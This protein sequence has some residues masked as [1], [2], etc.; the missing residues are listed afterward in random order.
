MAGRDDI[1]QARARGWSAET[2]AERYTLDLERVRQVFALMDDAAAGSEPELGRPTDTG[3]CGTMTGY[4][5]HRAAGERRCAKCLRARRLYERG[6]PGKPR[7]AVLEPCGTT[8]AYQRHHRRGEVPCEPCLAAHRKQC[9]ESRGNI[10]REEYRARRRE[11]YALTYSNPRFV[12]A[13]RRQRRLD[14]AR[15]KARMEE[16]S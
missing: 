15:K 8:A 16:A 12:E 6:K 7:A 13:R 11:L 5:R 10:T 3:A 1:E 2:I 9:A 4:A 14:Y